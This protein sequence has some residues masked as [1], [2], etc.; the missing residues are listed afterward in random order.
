MRTQRRSVVDEDDEPIEAR[1]HLRD[2]PL[3]TVCLAATA[4]Y[5]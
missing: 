2:Q 5:C 3:A 1:D 4:C